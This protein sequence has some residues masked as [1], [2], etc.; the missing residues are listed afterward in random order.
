MIKKRGLKFGTHYIA[1]PNIMVYRKV[2]YPTPPILDI[3]HFVYLA[4]DYDGTKIPNKATNSTVGDY[5]KCGDHMSKNGSGENCYLTNN[6]D[7]SSYL[8]TRL[9]TSDR[10]LMKADN[11][12]YTFFVRVMQDVST[13]VGGIISWR[14]NAETGPGDSYNYMIRCCNNKLEIHFNGGNDTDIS[15]ITDKV[16][17][18][19]VSGNNFTVTD[20]SNGTTWQ[21][22]DYEDK[23]MSV[24]MAS[25]VACGYGDPPF[26]GTEE[27]LDRFYAI[28]GIARATTS[29]EDSQISS[30]LMNQGL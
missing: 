6:L 1:R 13:A 5:L 21:G 23:G 2:D 7:P 17:K 18:I 12:T 3:M 25:F 19:Q 10:D 11:D 29:D 30:Y 27:Y 28:A 22:H 16:I 15:L 9:S 26:T 20:L 8:Y 24:Y 4:N 14:F